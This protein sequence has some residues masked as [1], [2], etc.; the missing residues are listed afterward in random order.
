M[1]IAGSEVISEPP[2]DKNRVEFCAIKLELAW[3]R[4][5]VR[6]LMFFLLMSSIDI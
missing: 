6:I 5:G 1:G 4:R 2:G 3:V